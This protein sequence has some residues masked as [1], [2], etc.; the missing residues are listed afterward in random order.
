M[1]MQRTII[2]I[3]AIAGMMAAFL[4]WT[5]ATSFDGTATGM[6]NNLNGFN[7]FGI[8]GFLAFAGV[9]L[10]T[11]FAGNKA[12]PPDSTMKLVVI[13]LGMIA[14]LATL[15]SIANSFGEIGELMLSINN[16]GPG[17]WIALIAAVVI[18]ILAWIFKSP[19][20]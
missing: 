18:V 20:E 3:T 12:M 4:P 9:V 17:T 11:L 7:G 16:S 2:L 13:S 10:M 14:L 19:S 6:R 15:I 1:N 8:I 5:V